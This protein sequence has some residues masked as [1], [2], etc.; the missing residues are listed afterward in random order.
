SSKKPSAVAEQ[1]P[2]ILNMPRHA[3]PTGS[4]AV[5]D[6]FDGPGSAFYGDGEG[7]GV[8]TEDGHDPACWAPFW[9]RG[10][11][12]KQHYD[13]WVSAEYLLWWMKDSKLPPLVTTGVPQNFPNVGSDR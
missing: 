1:K 13:F 10:E 8:C 7:L 6:P 5:P 4:L 12:F 3:G 11:C 2:E 9:R